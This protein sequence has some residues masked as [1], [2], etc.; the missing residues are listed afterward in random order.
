MWDTSQAVRAGLQDAQRVADGNG[1]EAEKGECGLATNM[2]SSRLT[3][4]LVV[5]AIAEARVEVDVYESLLAA[6]K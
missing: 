6:L 3:A 2:E 4:L 5:S 1:S